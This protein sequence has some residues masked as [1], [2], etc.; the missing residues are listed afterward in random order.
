MSLV[1]ELWKQFLVDIVSSGNVMILYVWAWS[2]WI[3]LSIKAHIDC[4]LVQKM[5]LLL[6]SIQTCA[7]HCNRGRY[8]H[9]WRNYLEVSLL[10]TR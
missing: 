10:P 2:A 1:L 4:G 8:G 3:V 7:C 5:I 9:H 6:T